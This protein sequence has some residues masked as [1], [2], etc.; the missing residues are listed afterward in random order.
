LSQNKAFFPNQSGTGIIPKVEKKNAELKRN[1]PDKI[2][3]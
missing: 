2:K 3:V 1:G